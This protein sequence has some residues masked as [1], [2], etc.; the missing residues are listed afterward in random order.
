MN[1]DN[2]LSVTLYKAVSYRTF[3]IFDDALIAKLFI[4]DSFIFYTYK[5]RPPLPLICRNS[6]DNFP[7]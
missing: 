6:Q 4:K 2:S 5:M 1:H 3:T 7:I